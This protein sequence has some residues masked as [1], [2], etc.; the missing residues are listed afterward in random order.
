MTSVGVVVHQPRPSIVGPGAPLRRLGSAVAVVALVAFVVAG[1]GE[2]LTAPSISRSPSQAA[3]ATEPLRASSARGPVA[4]ARATQARRDGIDVNGVMDRVSHRMV[5]VAPGHLVSVDDRYRASF[6][7][8][9]FRLGLRGGAGGAARVSTTAL[10]RGATEREIAAGPWRAQSN[11][12]SRSLGAGVVERVTAT[13]GGQ[14]EWDVVLRGPLAGSGDLRIDARVSGTVAQPQRHAGAWRW[15][16]GHG[17]GLTMGD[18]VVKDRTGAELYRSVPQ[19]DRS[20]VGL[21]VPASVLRDATY[22]LTVDPTVSPEYPASDPVTVAAIG[23]QA[24]AAVAFDGTNYL[25]AWADGRGGP[26]AGSDIFGTR[27]SKAG[28]VLDPLGIPISTAPG[29]QQSA[30]VAFD[31]TNYLVT[32]SSAQSPS[33]DSVSGTRVSKAGT[34]LDANGIPIA[35]GSQSGT[36]PAVAFDGTNYLVVWSDGPA[37]SPTDIY[38]ARVSKA[39]TVLDG[40]G[41]PI[42]NRPT[43]DAEPAVAFDGTNYLVVW[44]AQSDNQFDLYGARVS[45]AGTV[46]DS[47]GIPI[48]TS[49]KW[50]TGAGAGLRRHQLPRRMGGKQQLWS[51]ASHRRGPGQQ[52]RRGARQHSDLHFRT[53]DQA[54]G[55]VRSPSTAPTTS[56]PGWFSAPGPT[57]TCWR[58]GSPRRA[59]SSTGPDSRSPP[60]RATRLLPPWPSTAPTTWWRSRRRCRPSQPTSTAPESARPARS[61]TA[62]PSPSPPQ[63]TTR[64]SLRWPSM[65]PTTSS[66]G[67]TTAPV[68]RTPTSTGPGSARR[69]RPRRQRHPDLH[70]RPRPVRPGGGLRRHQ[71]PRRLARRSGHWVRG[72]RPGHPREP[73][74][75]GRRR[76]RR[77][78]DP[79]HRVRTTSANRPSPSTAPTTSSCGKTVTREPGST[80]AG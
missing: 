29:G 79:D 59:P 71:L 72:E 8:G 16:L 36:V 11:V 17:R 46:L 70:R 4:D 66:S 6:D 61:S 67:P 52:G 23:G 2:R 5:A 53:A 74:E 62:R 39:G 55:P 40:A 43:Y 56:S 38:G 48:A 26:D 13:G 18:V 35:T 65:A 10:M 73:G 37:S 15:D 33:S 3:A 64:P 34:V 28:T 47:A 24:D 78:R 75:Q 63:P 68:L 49:D 44:S 21:T 45:K 50:E 60:P 42:S 77:F 1:W 25:V 20:R 9:G 19:A 54:G 22:P 51:G 80:P 76:P 69:G 58:T 27:V 32:W 31:G 14:L 12:A 30:A 7:A 41:I 57:V